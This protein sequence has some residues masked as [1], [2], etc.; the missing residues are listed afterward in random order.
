[1]SVIQTTFSEDFINKIVKEQCKDVIEILS[2]ETSYVVPPGENYTCELLRIV[3][4]FSK[5]DRDD[6]QSMS[7]IVKHL[8]EG[9][10]AKSFNEEMGLFSCEFGIYCDILPMIEKLEHKEKVASKTYYASKESK[11]IIVMEDLSPL[12]YKM[13]DRQEGLNLEHCL[14]AIKKIAYF[15]VSSLALYEKNPKIMDYYNK[16]M[17]PKSQSFEKYFSVAFQGTLN[18]CKTEPSLQKYYQKISK[19]IKDK[20][21][22][23]TQRD[24]KLNVL[25]HG[26]FWC[27]NLMFQYNSD[28]SL[29][30]VLFVDFQVSF[31]ASP[32]YDLHY[33][34]ATSTNQEVKEKHINDILR[35]YYDAFVNNVKMLKIKTNVPDWTD[36]EKEFCDKAYMGFLAMCIGLPVIKANKTKD[37]SVTNFIENGEEGS[38]RYHCFSNSNYINTIKFLMPYYDDLGVFDS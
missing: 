10:L 24:S 15:H 25:N 35:H 36:F 32:F 22:T 13:A 14:L 30:D 21:Y 2:T 11:N 27:N 12:N 5:K 3:V 7:M 29:K 34:I 23:S 37:A 26:D 8:P 4:K 17:L 28:G 18:V 9:E 31:F 19:D 6:V 1:M 38:F 20:L 33:F 16:G